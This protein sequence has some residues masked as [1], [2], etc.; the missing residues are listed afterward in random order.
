[1]S[2]GEAEIEK[3][4]A[5]KEKEKEKQCLWDVSFQKE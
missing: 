1:M 3:A 5:E 2:I 4:E